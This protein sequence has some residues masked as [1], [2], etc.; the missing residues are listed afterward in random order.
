MSSQ[1]HEDQ[2]QHGPPTEWTDL[3]AVVVVRGVVEN[4]VPT[5][6]QS[7]PKSRPIEVQA[8]LKPPEHVEEIYALKCRHIDIG[9]HTDAQYL[10]YNAIGRIMPSPARVRVVLRDYRVFWY[11]M[12]RSTGSFFRHPQS[13][14]MSYTEHARFSLSLAW[15][16]AL[17]AGAS[18]IHAMW[19]DVL[20]RYTSDTIMTLRTRILNSGCREQE[21]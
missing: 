12:P 7:T 3:W 6:V 2:K 11:H 16:L 8:G 17:A 15:S 19:P 1:Q 4:A 9:L 20:E 5:N 18:V 10:R 13:V 21:P 14:C